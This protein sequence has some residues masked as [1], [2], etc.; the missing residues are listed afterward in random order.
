MNVKERNELLNIFVYKHGYAKELVTE[1]IDRANYLQY[2]LKESTA[3]ILGGLEYFKNRKYEN[4]FVDK[5]Q[6]VRNF[7]SFMNNEKEQRD[8]NQIKSVVEDITKNKQDIYTTIIQFIKGIDENYF[9]DN[10]EFFVDSNNIFFNYANEIGMNKYNLA[11]KLDNLYKEINDKYHDSF[12]FAKTI[13]PT[14]KS[15]QEYYSYLSLADFLITNQAFANGSLEES[16]N[17]LFSIDF[18]LGYYEGYLNCNSYNDFINND[19]VPDNF[20]NYDVYEEID[21]SINTYKSKKREKQIRS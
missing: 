4:K 7:N 21:L 5:E 1:L 2:D 19:Y 10:Q 15:N 6:Y 3:W 17:K 18:L 11:N 9:L 13:N 12:L 20:K 16:L 14:N 8:I